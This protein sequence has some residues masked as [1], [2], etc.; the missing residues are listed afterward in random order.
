MKQGNPGIL[1]LTFL[2]LTFSFSLE[3]AG[4]QERP[5]IKPLPQLPAAAGSTTPKGWLD[6]YSKA[7]VIAR[8]TNRPLMVF[9]TGSDWCGWCR[10]LRQDVLDTAAFMKFAQA[11]LVMVFVDSPR[12]IKLPDHLVRSN[13]SLS[14]MLRASGG[15]PNTILLDSQ[16]GRLGNIGGYRQDFQAEVTRLL[17]KAGYKTVK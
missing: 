6:D 8:Q 5:A 2:L 14:V 7:V 9:F 1:I 11:N 4:A 15:V 10:K 16:G 17:R 13:Q 12:R 3:A